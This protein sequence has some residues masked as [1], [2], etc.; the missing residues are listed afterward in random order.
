MQFISSEPESRSSGFAVSAPRKHQQ[1]NSSSQISASQW[2][3][4]WPIQKGKLVFNLND[5]WYKSEWCYPCTF[6][7]IASIQMLKNIQMVNTIVHSLC[8]R[9]G[10]FSVPSEVK[11]AG[12][13]LLYYYPVF[14]HCVVWIGRKQDSSTTNHWFQPVIHPGAVHL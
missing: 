3:L 11:K 2:V 1:R 14:H 12:P 9:N 5:N 13:V 10:L 7:L 6:V 8:I 4:K